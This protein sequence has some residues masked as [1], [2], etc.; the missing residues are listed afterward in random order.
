MLRSIQRPPEA[1][2]RDQTRGGCGDLFHIATAQLVVQWQ[3]TGPCRAKIQFQPETLPGWKQFASRHGRLLRL[4]FESQSHAGVEQFV[5]TASHTVQ[6]TP[7]TWLKCRKPV[8]T[9]PK[10]VPATHCL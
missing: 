4:R 9:M 5:G 2:K 7:P 10:A 6:R 8:L 3:A 1:S